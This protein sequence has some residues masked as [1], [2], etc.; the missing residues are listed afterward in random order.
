MAFA[1]VAASAALTFAAAPAH[2]Q[3]KAQI[4][5][6]VFEDL[7]SP[8]IQTGKSKAFKPK[9]WLEVEAGIKIPATSAEQK[10]S[11]FI[12]RVT[13]KWYVAVKDPEGKGVLKLEK[14][15]NHINVPVDEEIFSSVYLSPANIK[16]LTG[17][18]KAGKSAV[19]AVGIEVLVDS[20]KVGQAA[21]K[22]KDGWWTA[23]SLSNAS[24]RFPLL[25]K[26]ETPFAM[27][28]WDRFAE[29]Q[30]ER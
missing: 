6:L 5:N 10:K 8:E 17:K 9:D 20:T 4:S 7:P 15:I 23:A 24:D 3:V 11:G 29:I 18:D 12:D 14:T 27:F 30:K 22:Q 1:A 2:A 25:N 16:R 21:V 26:S 28:W 19:E 13:V